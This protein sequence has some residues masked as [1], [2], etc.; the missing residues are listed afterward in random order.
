MSKR[1]NPV[2]TIVSEYQI[3]SNNLTAN[4]TQNDLRRNIWPPILLRLT[5][6]N[7][8]TLSIARL[9]YLSISD[10]GEF[11]KTTTYNKRWLE[12]LKSGLHDESLWSQ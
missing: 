10:A 2:D 9:F 8:F 11:Y 12:N 5:R 1:F 4:L 7:Q 6:D 3:T